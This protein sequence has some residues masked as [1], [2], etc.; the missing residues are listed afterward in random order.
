MFSQ[1]SGPPSEVGWAL[2]SHFADE[3]TEAQEVSHGPQATPPVGA[4]SG[5]EPSSAWPGRPPPS[6]R[7]TPLPPGRGFLNY[8][9]GLGARCQ[10]IYQ[11]ESPMNTVSSRTFSVPTAHFHLALALHLLVGVWFAHPPSFEEIRVWFLSGAKGSLGVPAGVP[12]RVTRTA[13]PVLQ[14]RTAPPRHSV[15]GI[16]AGARFRNRS[17]AGGISEWQA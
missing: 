16:P 10:D 12:A 6:T 8:Q 9:K 17:L 4:R 13:L 14:P 5:L 3:E 15:S 1:S 11:T 7:P 2:E